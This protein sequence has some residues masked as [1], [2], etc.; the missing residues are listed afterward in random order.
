MNVTVAVVGTGRVVW[1]KVGSAL[2][3][4]E[5]A[6]YLASVPILQGEQARHRLGALCDDGAMQW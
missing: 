6:F 5:Q 3:V 1:Y 2:S 4:V